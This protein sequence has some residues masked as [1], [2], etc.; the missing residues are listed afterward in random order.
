[1]ILLQVCVC[2]KRCTRSFGYVMAAQNYSDTS[3]VYRMHGPVVEYTWGWD[4][5]IAQLQTLLQRRR[6]VS[7]DACCPV[8]DG[9]FHVGV[10][11]RWMVATR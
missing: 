9:V 11:L 3:A 6:L 10:V 2:R 1:M 8:S 7:A 5:W 4:V